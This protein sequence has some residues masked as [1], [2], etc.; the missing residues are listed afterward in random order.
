M[1]RIG[2]L[3]KIIKHDIKWLSLLGKFQKSP[4]SCLFYF[5]EV[6]KL[7]QLDVRDINNRDFYYFFILSHVGFSLMIGGIPLKLLKNM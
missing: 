2:Y 4:L 7:L 1:A 3:Y 5:V 6:K